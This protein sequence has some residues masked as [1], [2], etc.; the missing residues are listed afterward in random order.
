MSTGTKN[1]VT[2]MAK[3]AMTKTVFR[4]ANLMMLFK[5]SL[6]LLLKITKQYNITFDGNV[7][8]NLSFVDKR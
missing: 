7:K 8:R 1:M 3:R 5:N 4:F 2:T 6:P